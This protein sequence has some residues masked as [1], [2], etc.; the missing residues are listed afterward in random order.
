MPLLS[1]VSDQGLCAAYLFLAVDQGY[2]LAFFADACHQESNINSSLSYGHLDDKAL[3]WTF[4]RMLEGAQ[5]SN[6]HCVYSMLMHLQQ[7]FCE[8]LHI[9]LPSLCCSCV[10]MHTKLKRHA[11]SSRGFL[12]CIQSRGCPSDRPLRGLLPDAMQ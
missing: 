2:R 8:S 3:V 1:W 4:S 9:D 11:H 7:A 12:G 5:T 10:S 6:K